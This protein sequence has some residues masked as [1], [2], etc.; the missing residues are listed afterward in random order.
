[1]ELISLY[2]NLR[3]RNSREGFHLASQEAK[4][5]FGDDRLL[6]ERYVDQARHIE[7]QVRRRKS[8][9]FLNFLNIF[10]VLADSHGNAVN[11]ELNT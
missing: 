3:V 5:G 9:I 7:V 2:L 10:Q 4:S 1:M 11:I 8:K 6:I